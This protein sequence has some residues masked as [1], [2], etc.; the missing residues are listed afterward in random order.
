MPKIKRDKVSDRL[1]HLTQFE[2]DY[3]GA[4]Y[5]F[6]R[7][8]MKANTLCTDLTEFQRRCK[9]LEAARRENAVQLGVSIKESDEKYNLDEVIK[10]VPA[11]IEEMKKIY[12]SFGLAIGDNI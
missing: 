12:Q 8:V 11:V 4:S 1:W 10:G 2:D 6:A 5:T 3:S 9:N 7:L